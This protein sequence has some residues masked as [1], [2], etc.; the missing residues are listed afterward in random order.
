MTNITSSRQDES[1]SNEIQELISYRP[2]WVIR[3]GNTI[4]A[5]IIILL[6]TFAWFLRYPDI[7]KGSIVLVAINEPVPVIIG[8][9]LVSQTAAVKIK[10]GQRVLI[11]MK[12]L[13]GND[14]GYITGKVSAISKGPSVGDSLLIKVDLPNGMTTNY[15]KAILFSRNLDAQAEVVTD[16]KRLFERLMARIRT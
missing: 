16:S 5:L 8:Q 7:V 6:V 2:H 3:K 12:S 15:H 14:P 10:I 11:R 4:F 9:M 1:I 13:P